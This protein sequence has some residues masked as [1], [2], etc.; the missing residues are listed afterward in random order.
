MAA[1]LML[2]GQ[3]S[4]SSWTLHCMHASGASVPY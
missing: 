1:A 4:S 3:F 2:Q